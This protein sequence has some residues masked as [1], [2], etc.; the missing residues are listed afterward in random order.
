MNTATIFFLGQTVYSSSTMFLCPLGGSACAR[1]LLVDP[2][3]CVARIQLH[4]HSQNPQTKAVDKEESNCAVPYISSRI[5]AS[6]REE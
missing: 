1:S 5:N 3:T 4:L 6:T 2:N